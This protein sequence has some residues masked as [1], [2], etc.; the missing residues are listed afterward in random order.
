[1]HCEFYVSFVHPGAVLPSGLYFMIFQSIPPFRSSGLEIVS[2]PLLL[3]CIT[4]F[5]RKMYKG[6]LLPDEIGHGRIA[7]ESRCFYVNL[8]VWSVVSGGLPFPSLSRFTC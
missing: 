5:C 1:M 3:I 8:S 6:I 2:T 4:L 7:Y